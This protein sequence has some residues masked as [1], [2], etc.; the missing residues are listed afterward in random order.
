MAM[1]IDNCDVEPDGPGPFQGVRQLRADLIGCV[2]ESARKR[3]GG[4][5]LACGND[6]LLRGRPSRADLRLGGPILNEKHRQVHAAIARRGDGCANCC[7]NTHWCL[8]TV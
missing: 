5:F 2:S 7:R 6:R 1:P 3:V 4:V 8:G